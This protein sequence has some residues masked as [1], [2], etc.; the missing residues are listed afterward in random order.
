MND[1]K[2]IIEHE[3]LIKKLLNSIEYKNK[4]PQI[5]LYKMYYTISF[6]INDYIICYIIFF[7]ILLFY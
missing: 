5:Y 2:T 3:N 1:N 6:L 7:I 4:I